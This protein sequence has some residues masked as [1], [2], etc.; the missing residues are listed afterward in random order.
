MRLASVMEA[1][2]EYLS[3]EME[4]AARKLAEE[5]LEIRPGMTVV[6]T[7]DTSS[8]ARVVWASARAIYAAGGVPSVMWYHTQPRPQMEPPA[9]VAAAVAAA[10]IWIEQA[11]AYTMYTEAWQAALDAGVLYCELGG[12][13]VDGMVRCIGRQS[14][15]LMAEMGD[16]I[17]RLLTDAEVEVTSEAGSSI[18]F[19]NRGCKVGEFK[20]KTTPEKTPI[21][22]AGQVSWSPVED[23]MKGHLVADGILYPPSEVGIMNETVRFEIAKGRIVDIAGAREALVLK[24]WIDQLADDTM[25]RIAHVSM[26][27]NP[28]IPV[29]TGRVVEDERAFGDIDFGFGAWVG[30]PAAGHFDFT[31]R[32]VTIKANGV[33]LQENGRYTHPV[34]ARLCQ[35]MGVPHH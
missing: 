13:D 32:Q 33:P 10:E 11:V 35:A 20:M 16:E 28:G 34:L 1:R 15:G 6:I 17:I 2:D 19:S 25:Y 12:M 24:K 9:P 3:F 23:S 22:L 5:V 8:D 30:R 29:P 7:A 27:F 26:G 4:R 21:M 31:C 18:V 14:I